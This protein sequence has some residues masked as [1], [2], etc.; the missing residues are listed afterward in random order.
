MG[1]P[2]YQR[3]LFKA[4]QAIHRQR[5]RIVD[6][7]ALPALPT[8]IW[9]RVTTTYRQINQALVCDWDEAARR[10]TAELC[11]WLSDLQSAA[12]NLATDLGP[13]LVPKRVS[14]PAEIYRDLVALQ[15]E[16][17]AVE[18]D[19]EAAQV[20]V[21]TEPI[22]LD[23]V[24]LGRFEIRL[25]WREVRDPYES[26]RVVALDPN[27]AA[28]DDAVTH[29][30]V[31][32]ERLCE[33]EG[34]TGI[35][36]ALAEGRLFDFFTIV[37][38]LLHTYARGQAYV[39]LDRW[40]GMR[41]SDCSSIV[42]DGDCSSCDR[43]EEMICCDCTNSCPHCQQICCASCLDRCPHCEELTC[44]GCLEHCSQCQV[45]VCPDCLTDQLCRECNETQSPSENEPD[46][47]SEP[48]AA[49]A[50]APVYS[51]R[52]GQAVVPAGSGAD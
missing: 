16:P 6:H 48:L 38:R 45:C 14:A 31:R 51:D 25:D 50:D 42:D 21:R 39:E 4:A 1:R 22:E 27:P 36:R 30:H 44:P 41:C 34:R 35:R 17:L 13:R 37:D 28:C 43:C 52:L 19:Y 47:L 49:A 29:P 2:R 7:P 12:R 9:Q 11:D 8:G 10:K 3:L 20:C 32:D 15:Q 24:A 40:S 18:V 26:Y 5:C 46:R 33:G 23:S